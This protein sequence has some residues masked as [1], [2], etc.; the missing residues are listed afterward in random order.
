[1]IAVVPLAGTWIEIVLFLPFLG[2]T[3]MVVPLAGT[4]IE[5]TKA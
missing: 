1:M 4:W 3:D 5:M 2:R